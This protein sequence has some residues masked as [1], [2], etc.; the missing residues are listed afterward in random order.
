MPAKSFDLQERQYQLQDAFYAAYPPTMQPVTPML[1]IYEYFDDFVI[2][3]EAGTMYKVS[4]IMDGENAVFAPRDQWQ[5]AIEKSAWVAVKVAGDNL[6]DVLAIPFTGKDADGQWFDA[7]TDIMAESFSTPVAV[8]QHGITQGGGAMDARPVIV[9]RTVPG[10][11]KK[12]RDGW[13]LQVALDMTKKLV[14]GI[15]D[16]ARSGKVA[17][18]SGSVSHLT[19]LE[20][21]GKL[22]S[23]E[24]NKPGRI[25][26]WPLAE[27]SLW[28][29]GNGNHQPASRFAMAA[30]VLKAIYRDANIAFPEITNTDSN[31]PEAIKAAK[32]KEIQEAARRYL[33]TIKEN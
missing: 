26:V 18:S 8:Y 29:M 17:V 7:D 24:K 10:T 33:S 3:C 21:N 16:A 13:H 6:L 30:P 27:I 32:K 22:Q 15:M 11:L 2:V 28:E 19:R 5:K 23:Y 14:K 9:G 31:S 1:E 12:A 4:Y 20:V 25:A